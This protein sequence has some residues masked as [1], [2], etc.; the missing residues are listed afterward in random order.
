MKAIRVIKAKNNRAETLKAIRNGF[1]MEEIIPDFDLNNSIDLARFIVAYRSV[2]LDTLAKFI[3]VIPEMVKPVITRWIKKFHPS[4]E[5]LYVPESVVF[6]EKAFTPSELSTIKQNSLLQ[7]T[8]AV[9]GYNLI[10]AIVMPMS[11]SLNIVRSDIFLTNKN[12]FI[13][14]VITSM[15]E[16]PH[17][18]HPHQPKHLFSGTWI[19]SLRSSLDKNIK[20]SFFKTDNHQGYTRDFISSLHHIAGK[21]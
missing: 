4:E 10:G 17:Y 6:L 16:Q 11:L 21:W 7:T 18:I 2:E 9:I 12:E 19:N 8:L 20:V 14:R 15:T 5:R 3:G 13:D 1:A